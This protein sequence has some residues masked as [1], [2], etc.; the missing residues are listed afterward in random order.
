V[1]PKT[2][3]IYIANQKTASVLV[4][5]GETNT[6]VATLKA[7]AIPYAMAVDTAANQVYVANFSGDNATVIHGPASH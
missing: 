4:L 7:G 1:N 2:N 6:T 3:Q 5:D